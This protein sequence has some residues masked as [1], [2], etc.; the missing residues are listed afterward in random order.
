MAAE[1]IEQFLAMEER[2]AQDEAAQQQWETEHKQARLEEWL[3]QERKETEIIWKKSS[4]GTR[5]RNGG[6]PRPWRQPTC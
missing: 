1:E 4:Q 2:L 3:E 6:T 5:G